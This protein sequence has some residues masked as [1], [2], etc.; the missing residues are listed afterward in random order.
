MLSANSL[1]VTCSALVGS[2]LAPSTAMATLPLG[3]QF[4]ATMLT[5]LPASLFMKKWGR[6]AG[7]L[8][9]AVAAIVGG[10]FC[11][12]G[13]F[14]HNFLLFSLGSIAFGSANG[15]SQFYRFAAAELV[16]DSFRSRAISWVLAGGL[17]AAFVG[18]SLARFSRDL[19]SSSPFTASFASISILG[20]LVILTLL[21]CSF[22][23]PTSVESHG[24]RRPLLLIIRQPLFIVAALS[25]MTAYGVMNLLMSATPLAMESHRHAF[26][27]TAVVIQWHVVGMFLPSFFTG[28]LIDRF[29]VLKIMSCGALL[30]L[31]SALISL[32]GTSFPHFLSGLILLG[33]G[34]NFLFIGATSLLTNAY[35]PAEKGITQGL[36]DMLVFTTTSLTAFSSG[37]LHSLLGWSL[38]NQL[39]IPIIAFTALA[40]LWLGLIH[41]RAPRSAEKMIVAPNTE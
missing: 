36:N 25:A 17:A 7:F 18:P 16:S 38:L 37:L 12:W 26:D 15:F 19:L 28:S 34:W 24:H 6:K 40:I 1:V 11:A 3:L 4:T 32:S 20:L 5:T 27:Q 10:L 21:F 13:I 8:L 2:A 9:G 29:G 33:S 30:L 31:A 22:P 23:N 39:A 14:S 35:H 41:N